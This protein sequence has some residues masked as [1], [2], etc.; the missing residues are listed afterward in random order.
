MSAISVAAQD[1][2]RGGELQIPLSSPQSAL[3]FPS[4]IPADTQ[5]QLLRM[6]RD[7][8]V[9]GRADRQ[10]LVAQLREAVA[11]LP[12]MSELRVLLGMAL[13]V[14]L[15]AQQALEELRESVR[16]APRSFIAQ[17]KFGELLMRLRICDQA[18]AH[19]QLAAQLAENSLQSELARSQAAT[20]R[21]MQREGIERGGYGKLRSV[22]GRTQ[23]A[24]SRIPARIPFGR[25]RAALEA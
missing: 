2:T 24:L 21:T 9:L 20:I 1:D 23:Q 16:L 4:V 10:E 12:A 5:E 17:L 15:E 22:F 25:G 11:L 19:T 14:N 3:A 6:F 8:Y 13:C 7:P 18:A